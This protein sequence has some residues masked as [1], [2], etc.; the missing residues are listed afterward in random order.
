MNSEPP[1]KLK[2]Y[3]IYKRYKTCFN[4]DPFYLINSF[5][6]LKLGDYIKNDLHHWN[7]G[8]GGSCWVKSGLEQGAI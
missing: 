7:K 4:K 3:L 5:K 8:Q 1:N 2:E 6:H